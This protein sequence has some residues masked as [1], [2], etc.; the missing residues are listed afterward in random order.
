MEIV[1]RDIIVARVLY[2]GPQWNKCERC[3][4][5]RIFKMAKS[6]RVEMM[7][8]MKKEGKNMAKL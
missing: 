8:Q 1:N 6:N 4:V 3:R 7:E 2:W 5:N